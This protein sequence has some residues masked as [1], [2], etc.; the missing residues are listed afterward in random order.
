MKGF[1]RANLMYMRAFA[2]AWPDSQIVQQAVG[3][4]PWGHNLALLTKVKDTDVRLAYARLALEHNW[5]RAILVH[6][7]ETRAHER[8]GQ[9]VTNFGKQL[10][11]PQSELA[12]ESL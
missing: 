11:A 6:Q 4:L 9:A 5:S 1:S 12:R 10:P 8:P 7:I 2:E 3:Q